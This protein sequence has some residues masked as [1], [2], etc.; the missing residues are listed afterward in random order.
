MKCQRYVSQRLHD[1]KLT[2][3]YLK[4]WFLLAST[5]DE[6]SGYFYNQDHYQCYCEQQEW[7]AIHKPK[8]DSRVFPTK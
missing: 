3:M 2:M 7:L 8:P 1:R 5:Q 6:I 4:A